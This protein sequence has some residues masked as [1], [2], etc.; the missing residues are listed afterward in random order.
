VVG[1]VLD[2]L[3]RFGD[4]RVMVVSDHL[5]PI[6]IRTHTAEPTPFAWAAKS[7]IEKNRADVGFSEVTA[8]KSLLR[9]EKGHELMDAFVKG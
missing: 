2:G 8:E 9:Y 3:Q 6:A 4:Y 7:E 5:T 1:A